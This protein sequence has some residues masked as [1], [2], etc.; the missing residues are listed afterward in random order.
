MVSTNYTA[1]QLL[2]TNNQFGKHNVEGVL[3]HE[4]YSYRIEEISGMRT[5]QG[6][7][8]LYVFSNFADI[9]SLSSGLSEASVESYFAR[10][11]YNYDCK[12]YLSATLR[13][14]GNSKFPEHLRWE[15][16][17]SIGAAW[18]IDQESFV[19]NPNI[20]LLKL[21]ASYGQ[22]GNSDLGN[23]PYQPG[24]SIGYNNASAS[25]A[26]LTSLG[27][28]EL[29][30]ETQKPLDLGL[31]FSFY[32]GKISG[33][34]DYYYRNSD[35]L[36]FN[37]QQPYH[38]GGTTGGSFSISRNVGAMTNKGIELTVTGGLIRKPDFSWD[39]TL[40]VTTLKN[41][42]TKMPIE[43][44]EIVRCP[45][46]RVEGRSIYDYYTRTF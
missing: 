19:S 7:E 23:Y 31:D 21:R 9:S 13:R 3:G 10:A 24:Y 17:W 42:I 16:F 34:F 30:W 40:N 44:P 46:K 27:S 28:N 1:N 38:N 32:N 5:G 29:T 25:G 35:G 2:R 18:R 33:T 6:F 36:L 15:N 12:Y 22:M 43:T 41:E 37:V 26:V 14:D 8:G 11:N 45:Y 39:L 4:Y 20:D